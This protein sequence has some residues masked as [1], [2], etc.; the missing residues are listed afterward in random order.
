MTFTV[1][2]RAPAADLAAFL[3]ADLGARTVEAPPAAA[4]DLADLEAGAAPGRVILSPY[5]E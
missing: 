1:G 5:G 3:L 2:S 4:A